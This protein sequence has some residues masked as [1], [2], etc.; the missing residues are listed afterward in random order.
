MHAY[1]SAPTFDP[2]GFIQIELLPDT[3]S[4]EKRRR[5]NRIPTLD[6]G[7]AFNDFGYADADLQIDLLWRPNATADAAVDRLIQLYGVVTVS[8]RDG[9]FSAIP[10]LYVPGADRSSLRLLVLERL[11]TV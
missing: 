8:T 3:V 11:S 10:D 5:T 9:V 6:G 4:P 2:L 1:L 7:A